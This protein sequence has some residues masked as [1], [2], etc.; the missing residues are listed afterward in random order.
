MGP[1]PLMIQ[2]LRRA[3][4]EFLLQHDFTLDSLLSRV[5]R[6]TFCRFLDQFWEKFAWDW[7]IQLTGNPIVEIYNGI[8]LSAGGELG[9]GV[10][11]E[12]WGSGEREVLEDFVTRTEGLVDLIV[13]RFGDPSNHLEE[14]PASAR[15]NEQSQWLGAD[16]DPRSS[17]GV[18]FTG[19]GA[20]S[21]R[22]LSQVSH[23]ME[24]I[25]RFGD[26]AYG[27][28]RDPTSLRRRKRRKQRAGQTSQAAQQ[29]STPDRTLTPGIPRP[30]ITATPQPLPGVGADNQ[31]ESNNEASLLRTQEKTDNATFPTETVM[32]YL[33][34]GY[35]S[36]WSFSP[37]SAHT[38]SPEGSTPTQ[39]E[40]NAN[41]SAPKSQPSSAVQSQPS[42]EKRQNSTSNHPSGRFVLGPRDDLE[43]LDDIE[44]GSPE[45]DSERGTPKTRIVHRSLYVQLAGVPD[46]AL[47]RLQVVIYVVCLFLIIVCKTAS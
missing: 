8:K 30:L 45:P 15:S 12:E 19:V 2:Q 10:G 42:S 44:E 9:I 14:S 24:R 17:D 20:L 28:G 47:K 13:S 35:G 33:T 11:E 41:I 7:E 21:R 32:K 27:V 6:S 5:G 3:H 25:Y 34:L 38:P 22:S 16:N 39:D 40:P 23:W 18:V 4:W 26:A 37:K 31:A 43:I 29:P 36:S 46:A 1:P